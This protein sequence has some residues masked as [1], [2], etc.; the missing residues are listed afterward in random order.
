MARVD[1]GSYIVEVSTILSL[2]D[3]SRILDWALTEAQ[4]ATSPALV[5]VESPRLRLSIGPGSLVSSTEPPIPSY[6]VAS[7]QWV[8]T[9]TP[10]GEPTYK[11]LGGGMR[12][13]AVVEAIE[14][15][16]LAAILVNGVRGVHTLQ[17]EAG[18]AYAVADGYKVLDWS[19]EEGYIVYTSSGEAYRR[20]SYIAP[21]ASTCRRR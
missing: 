6:R 8:D 16:D 14:Y 4:V 20:L 3:P 17:G 9:C 19:P 5:Y 10:V 11:V 7:P 2:P 21:L 15:R 12:I 1:R 18:E 13:E